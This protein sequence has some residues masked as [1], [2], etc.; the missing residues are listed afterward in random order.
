MK[1]KKNNYQESD[2][3][4]VWEEKVILQG[5]EKIKLE[6]G[7][8][9]GIVNVICSNMEETKIMWLLELDFLWYMDIM[10]LGLR[11]SGFS[12]QQWDVYLKVS[13]LNA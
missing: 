1:D 8:F 2:I 11:K 7:K 10:F 12:F 3:M 6:K 13:Y 9:E 4:F 5:L